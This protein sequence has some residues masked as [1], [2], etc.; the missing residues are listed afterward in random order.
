MKS[1]NSFYSFTYPLLDNE[2]GSMS[3]KSLVEKVVTRSS[4]KTERE[5]GVPGVFVDLTCK[6]RRR[7][8]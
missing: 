6:R 4:S 8:T 3:L 5:D 1:F 7:R 2:L